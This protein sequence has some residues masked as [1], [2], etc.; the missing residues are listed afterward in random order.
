MGF[1]RDVK[2][3][4]NLYDYSR[5]FFGIHHHH[6]CR[7]CRAEGCQSARRKILGRLEA[8]HLPRRNPG[9]DTANRSPS[10]EYRLANAHPSMARN[11]LSRCRI[12]GYG[13][14]YRDA[15]PHRLPR[16]LQQL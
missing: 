6:H 4:P 9:R 3:M 11:R 1:L 5:Q 7:R 13:K 12:L 16:L 8:R 2:D 14:G 15:R 10:G